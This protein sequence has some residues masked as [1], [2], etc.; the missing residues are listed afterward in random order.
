MA[1]LVVSAVTGV[2]A[3][4]REHYLI[5]EAV[6]LPVF[7]VVTKI[8]R[9]SE[10]QL[11]ATLQALRELLSTGGDVCVITSENELSSCLSMG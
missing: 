8:D 4:T 6:G 3:M 11:N 10:M 9:V 5:A 2:T 1:C 7:V